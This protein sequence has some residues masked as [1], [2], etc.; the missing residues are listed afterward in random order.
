MGTGSRHHAVHSRTFVCPRQSITRTPK[1]HANRE[2]YAPGAIGSRPL[3]LPITSSPF[4]LG[5]T[6]LPFPPAPNR[7]N[8]ASKMYRIRFC[9][10]I[11]GSMLANQFSGAGRRYGWRYLPPCHW[12]S[13]DEGKQR[14]SRYFT[15]PGTQ[16]SKPGVIKKI[17]PSD[18]AGRLIQPGDTDLERQNALLAC[19]IVARQRGGHF[20]FRSDAR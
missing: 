7:A 3:S 8:P 16:G 2:V 10:A 6:R 14:L 17:M 19:S 13:F 15:Q 12:Y 11:R 5:A 1:K 18:S 20:P 9:W 4:T